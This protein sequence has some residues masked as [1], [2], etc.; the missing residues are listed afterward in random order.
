MRCPNDAFNWLCLA[1][2]LVNDEQPQEAEQAIRHAM[3]LNPFYPVNYLAVLADLL[4]HQ[5]RSHEALD[6]L[7]ELVN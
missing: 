4:V 3:R 5:G 7:D 6:V 2:L 1:R